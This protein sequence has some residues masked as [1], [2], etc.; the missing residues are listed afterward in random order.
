MLRQENINT[1]I[2][3]GLGLAECVIGTSMAAANSEYDVCLIS[4]AMS[5]DPDSLKPGLPERP[6]WKGV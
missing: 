5:T 3:T 1:L 2:F 6:R 4:D